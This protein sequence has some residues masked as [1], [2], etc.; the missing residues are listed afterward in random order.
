MD[1]L[2]AMRTTGTCRYF[3]NT[4]VPDSVLF[5]AFEAARFGPQGGNRQPA[6]WIVVREAATK[7][8]LA[9]LYLPHW[10]KYTG[11]M[12]GLSVPQ[13]SMSRNT[14]PAN[15]FAENF[16]NIP[17]ISVLCARADALY[18]TDK[19]LGRR[20]VVGGASIYP[21]M[22]NVCLA[23]RDQGV[24]TAVTT[25]LCAEEPAVKELLEIPEEF[26]TAAHLGIG[27]PAKA[28]PK[29]LRR[30]PVSDF[31]FTERFGAALYD[32]S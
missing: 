29:K 22:Q 26:I 16:A 4:D 23:L 28:F 13:S 27:Y 3:E 12:T 8:S 9:E 20:S 24:A 5:Q 31:V 19:D 25:F 30:D 21:H 18:A 15:D 14:S 17:I 2:E 11:Q 32:E 1:L 10:R 6:R 7:Q